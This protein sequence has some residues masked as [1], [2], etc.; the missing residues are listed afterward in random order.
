MFVDGVS[1][2]VDKLLHA[3]REKVIGEI[4]NAGSGKAISVLD[5]AKAVASHMKCPS[6]R[7]V[8]VPDRPG[9]VSSFAAEYGKAKRVLGWTPPL[10]FDEGLQ[11]TIAWYRD[12][13]PIWEDQIESVP[14]LS[15]TIDDLDMPLS[16]QE[17]SPESSHSRIKI[18]FGINKLSVGGAE[19]LLVNQIVGMDKKRFDPHLVTL[20][21]STKPNFDDSVTFLGSKWKKFQFA[22][23]LDVFSWFSLVSYLK[24]EKFDVVITN[25]FLTNFLLRTAAI[26]AGVPLIFSTELNVYEKRS[27]VW[28]KI[29][30]WLA[31]YTHKIIAVS[32]DVIE[33]ASKQLS[34]PKDKFILNYSTVNLKDIR[35]ATLEERA[36][37][38]AK[39]S[40]PKD[41]F[42]IS[43]AGRLV[44][45]KGQRFLIEAFA[46]LGDKEAHL[47]VFGEG[48][49]RPDLEE[50]VKNHGLEHNIH[51]PGAVS[52]KDI[53]ALSDIFVLPSLWEG[54]PLILLEA[55]AGGLPIVATNIS[56]ARELI[57]DG[58]NG[59]LVPPK[60]AGALKEKILLLKN[61][62]ALKTSFRETSLKG[63][64]KFSIENHLSVL[65]DTIHK[66]L[67]EKDA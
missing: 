45:Q 9:Q 33:S 24:R 5:V 2:M 11:K 59:F 22:G 40:V 12:N 14:S 48:A 35:P 34:L 44:E 47:F 3:P 57:E 54:M 58:N 28:V 13:K 65:Y 66:G 10:D 43:T 29:E 4:F 17:L 18:L 25:L 21:P 32:R 61:D 16:N 26:V 60:D 31:P 27:P 20:L 46:S 39:Y 30:Q 23:L 63:V 37:V 51:L 41:A 52:I 7:F 67:T 64:Q 15:G 53:V 56:G 1:D 36:K 8:F 38:R 62:T 19:R 50:A 42:V 55:M 6:D 49:R